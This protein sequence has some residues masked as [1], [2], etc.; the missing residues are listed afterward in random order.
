MPGQVSC[1]MSWRLEIQK[2]TFSMS[3]RKACYDVSYKLKAVKCA[4]DKSKEAAA[5]MFKV[6]HVGF[7]SGASR[8]RNCMFLRTGSSSHRT[9]VHVALYIWCPLT[10]L[11]LLVLHTRPPP[12]DICDQFYLTPVSYNRRV[13]CMSKGNKHLGDNTVCFYTL[14]VWL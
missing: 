12:L 13:R 14:Q 1:S 9:G 2:V 10:T 5:R 11:S 4:E 7:A 6:I 3:K 8:R